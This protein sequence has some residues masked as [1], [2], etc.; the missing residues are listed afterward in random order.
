MRELSGRMNAP[1]S[2]Y[3]AIVLSSR[4]AI[5][6]LVFDSSSTVSL[7]VCQERNIDN[8]Q[9]NFNILLY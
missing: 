5:T 8:N 4:V 3:S 7:I 2:Q 1:I 6:A 9:Q